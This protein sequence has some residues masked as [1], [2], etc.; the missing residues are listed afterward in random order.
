[1]HLTIAHLSDVH[2]APL[3]GLGVGHANLKR[4]LGLAN[5]LYKRRHVHL[6]S[7]VDALV[8]DLG[9]HRIDHIV[10]SGDLTNL[11]LPG[12]H[13]HALEWL[14][15]VGPPERVS[16]VPGNHD[17][18]CRLW[19]DPGVERW[20]AYMRGDAAGAAHAEGGVNGF[21]YVRMLGSLA[22][23][24]VN[25]AV[26]TRPGEAIGEVGEPQLAALGRTLE[27][28]GAMGHR[29]LVVIHHPPLP[30]QA[31][32]RRGL[33]DAARLEQVLVRH[34]PDLVIHGHNHR[35]MHA[36]RRGADGRSTHVVGIASA[37]IGRVHSH[38]PLGRYNLIR[39]DPG[40]LGGAIEIVSRGIAAPG[41]PVVEVGRRMLEAVP[42]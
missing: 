38:E 37:S 31:D 41:G 6:R 14:R 9:Q 33:R 21:P 3:R 1:M 36:V 27:R 29:R 19:R 4:A 22:L 28:L 13:E 26:P 34:A 23:V 10:V 24:G 40:A 30:G 15:S 8:A 25:S 32:S 20:R 18:Y 2:L 17:I 12:E 42:A 39:I 35:D 5:W 7:V 16:V 11:G